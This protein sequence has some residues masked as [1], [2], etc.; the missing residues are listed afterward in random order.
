MEYY[1]PNSLQIDDSSK[2]NGNIILND[3]IVKCF[4]LSDSEIEFL[5]HQLQNES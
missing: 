3:S 5:D 1:I 2:L 4:L